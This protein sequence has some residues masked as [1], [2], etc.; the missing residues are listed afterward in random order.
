[1]RKLGDRPAELAADGPLRR[2]SGGADEALI[3]V[4]CHEEPDLTSVAASNVH[5]LPVSFPEPTNAQD[6][7]RDKARK[8]RAI[9]AWPGRNSTAARSTSCTSMQTISCT[10]TSSRTRLPASTAAIW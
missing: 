9:G 7:G 10:E 3:V 1:M 2:G 8:R 5:I 6:A 4:A